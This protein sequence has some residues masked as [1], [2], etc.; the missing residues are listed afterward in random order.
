[1]GALDLKIVETLRLPYPGYVWKIFRIT[2]VLWLL[3]RLM[4]TVFLVLVLD[5][6]GSVAA[7]QPSLGLPALLVWIDRKRSHEQLLHA[8]LGAWE[9]W[10]WVVSL[11]LALGLDAVVY[12][13]LS[14]L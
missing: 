4:S 14:S 5:V 8:N 9:G 13:L 7:S 3:L 6:E 1:M 12:L 2:A 11:F 10:F